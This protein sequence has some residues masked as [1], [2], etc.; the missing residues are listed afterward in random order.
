MSDLVIGDNVY[1][2]DPILVES[3][4]FGYGSIG[5]YPAPE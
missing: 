5:G 3:D 2:M 1:L 4:P